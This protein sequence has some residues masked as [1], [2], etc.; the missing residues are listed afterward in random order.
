MI[1]N[2]ELRPVLSHTYE[3]NY[4]KLTSSSDFVEDLLKDLL[5]D[6]R[7]TYLVVDG[8]DEVA[9]VERLFLLE[10]LMRLQKSQNLK[11]L[12]SS[13]AEYDIN[14]LLALQCERIQVHESNA[15]DI[16]DYIDY[17]TNNWLSGLEADPEI[18]SELGR[19][20]EDI[21]LKSKGRLSTIRFSWILTAE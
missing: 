10:S 1:D 5:R 15:Q 7:T 16:S 14:L 12:I 21:A 11:L 20:T 8:M 3:N 19:H 9:E 2:K 13:R 17:R 18:I 4:R 6:S